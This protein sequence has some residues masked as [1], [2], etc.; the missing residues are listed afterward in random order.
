MS[1]S[2]VPPLLLQL[3][4]REQ[5]PAEMPPND[6]EDDDQQMSDSDDMPYIKCEAVYGE[7]DEDDDMSALPFVRTEMREEDDDDDEDKMKFGMKAPE[8]G[9]Y[10]KCS[11][12]SCHS[13]FEVGNPKYEGFSHF[14]F[15]ED[16][17]LR[18]RWIGIIGQK[19]DWKP[20]GAMICSNHFP[21]GSFVN[22]VECIQETGQLL[23]KRTLKPGALPTINLELPASWN[24]QRLVLPP[25]N[26]VQAVTP[27]APALP[28]LAPAAVPPPTPIRSPY[29]QGELPLRSAFY[30]GN[31]TYLQILHSTGGFHGF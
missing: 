21:E 27:I 7:D 18:R 8:V 23:S 28:R 10:V 19:E 1:L 20:E 15:P 4:G 25:N 5:A 12:P 14:K 13:Y 30:P 26:G 9:T 6:D 16:P 17:N 3:A 24:M 29:C 31:P 11:V 22:V 2:G